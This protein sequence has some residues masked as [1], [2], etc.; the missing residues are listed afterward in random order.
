MLSTLT[1]EI[2]G[3][4]SRP[5]VPP[6][7]IFDERVEEPD[8]FLPSGPIEAGALSWAWS[9]ESMLGLVRDLVLARREHILRQARRHSCLAIGTEVRLLEHSEALLHN[10]WDLL[11]HGDGSVAIRLVLVTLADTLPPGRLQEALRQ[12]PLRVEL[13]LRPRGVAAF[14]GDY[15][16]HGPAEVTSVSAASGSSS[17]AQYVDA[18]VAAVQA[19]ARRHAEMM[20]A[21]RQYVAAFLVQFG[22]GTVEYDTQAFQRLALLLEYKRV[23][24]VLKIELS[25]AF[26][27]KQPVFTLL[28]ASFGTYPHVVSDYP[29]SPR[30]SPDEMARRAR[31][32]LQESMPQVVA[33]WRRQMPA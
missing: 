21:R 9:P 33:E 16:A 31:T 6:D 32:Y 22:S 24:F 30:W 19:Q 1:W 8:P 4:Q 2:L 11:V 27:Q 29:Y 18:A 26:P 15:T 12:Q 23:L 17:P 20:A 28:P 25:D 14:D 3:D 7:F 5:D 13:V 10:P